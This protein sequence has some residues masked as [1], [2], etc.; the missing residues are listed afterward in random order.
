VPLNID[1]TNILSYGVIGLGFLLAFLAYRLSS[2]EQERVEPRRS[3]LVTI[4]VFMIFSIILCMI[5]FG[6]EYVRRL[7]GDDVNQEVGSLKQ[8][9]AQKEAEIK[10]KQAKVDARVAEVNSQALL[11][12][13]YRERARRQQDRAQQYIT[14]LRSAVVIPIVPATAREAINQ[15]IDLLQLPPV[16]PR[17]G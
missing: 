3:I 8:Q 16:E 5:G 15:L 13:R 1:P 10:S 6:S 2:K 14:A 9:V 4:H 11:L 7:P 17:V 12:E